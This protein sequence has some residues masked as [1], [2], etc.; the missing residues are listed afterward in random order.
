MKR[1]GVAL[2]VFIAQAAAFGQQVADDARTDGKILA[3]T[4]RYF[5]AI[6][7]RDVKTLDEL[8]L[9]KCVICYPRAVT[10]T[11]ASLIE[12]VSKASPA[13]K[14]AKPQYTLSD[15]KVRRVG[16][17]AILTLIRTA[18]GVDSPGV[19]NTSQRTLT[20]VRHD[21][22]WRL[23]H[24]QWSLAGDAQQA[25]YWSDYFRG[26]DQNFKRKPNSLLVQAVA[27]VKPG[28]ALD[29]GMGE[30]RNAIYLARHGWHVTGFDR[31]EGALAVARQQARDQ[32]LTITPILQ[33]AEEF[34][35]GR[36]QW[37]LVALLYFAAVRENVA[38]IRESLRPGG[39]VVV[40]AFLAPPGTPARGTEYSPGQLRKLFDEDFKI[41]RYEETEGVADYGQ[42]R[43]QMVRLVATKLASQSPASSETLQPAAATS[44]GCKHHARRNRRG[45]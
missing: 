21:G 9:A 3:Q 28:R 22:R 36:E 18:T 30:G 33:S 12:A 13:D 37:D 6:E 15:I 10:D 25:E 29:A 17:T 4:Q 2:L 20:W 41:L 31:A 34:D 14:P 5:D 8:L 24:D 11:K 16:D 43:M 40:E 45:G 23:M 39:L 44:N 27:G 42:K 26:K 32:G 19:I 1:I 38:K 7:R 35:W